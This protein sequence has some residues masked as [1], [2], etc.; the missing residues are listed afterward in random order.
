MGVRKASVGAHPIADGQGEANIQVVVGAGAGH[1]TDDSRPVA[2]VHSMVGGL[3]GAARY[4]TVACLKAE[5]AART[6]AGPTS[7]ASTAG[8]ASQLLV[9]YKSVQEHTAAAGALDR[10][11]VVDYDCEY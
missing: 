8:E 9:T 10:K 3:A 7:F 5:E 2:G 6:T 11:A 1:M 4:Y